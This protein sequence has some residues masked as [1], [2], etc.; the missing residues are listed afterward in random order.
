MTRIRSLALTLA[1]AAATL[2]APALARADRLLPPAGKVFD[3]VTGGR[4]DSDYDSFTRLVGVHGA[5]YQ[6]FLNW[7]PDRRSFLYMKTRFDVTR[8][9]GARLM[10]HVSTADP[11][12]HEV[13]SPVAIAKGGGDAYLLNLNRAIARSGQA[14]YVRLMAEMNNFRNPYSAYGASGRRRDAAHSTRAFK[15]AWKRA[16]LIVRGGPA[17]Q[18]DARLAALRLP[19]VRN[20]GADIP[21]AR[22]AF[23]WVP[24]TRGSPDVAGNA[25]R[26]YYPGDAWVDWIGTDF[27]SGFPNFGWLDR[28]Y[29]GF[30][31]RKPFA[32]AEWGV[33]K[34]GDDAAFVRRLFGWI[35]RHR[36][37]RMALYSQGNRPGGV[38]R[39]Q[40]YPRAA[41]A[42][43]R[44][45]RNGRFAHFAPA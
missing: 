7:N 12:G 31:R 32:F 20:G 3:G 42:A 44:A 19:P 22:V 18:V 38:F 6:F 25:P 11:N 30:A 14:A 27:Y 34:S 9:V 43:R 13:I 10:F 23:L 39:L 8:R 33:W 17:A 36:A 15:L 5:I 41:A 28:F 26:A 29:A 4:D 1:V 35:G 40:R 37:V 45:L 16:V 21:R 24:Q 2:A